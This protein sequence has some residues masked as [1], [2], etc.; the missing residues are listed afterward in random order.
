MHFFGP[1]PLRQRQGILRLLGQLGRMR[2]LLASVAMFFVFNVTAQADGFQLPYNPDSEPDGY[3]GVGDVLEVLSIFGS[4]WNASD[5]YLDED[6]THIVMNVGSMTFPECL[7]TCENTLPGSWR[8]ATIA[9]AG[10]AWPNIKND[11][12]WINDV[13]ALNGNNANTGFRRYRWASNGQVGSIDDFDIASGCYCATQERPKVEYLILDPAES[14]VLNEA[15]EIEPWMNQK[16][17]EGWN[18]MATPV[19][20]AAAGQWIYLWRWAD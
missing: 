15:S 3:I 9:D 8:V 2:L 11:A 13:D 18:P 10:G 16:A 20:Y 7:Y 6:S 1:T 4:Q 12:A 17:Q 19:G 5:V 14:N